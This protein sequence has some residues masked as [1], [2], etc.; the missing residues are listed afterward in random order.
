MSRD[1]TFRMRLPAEKLQRWREAAGADGRSLT[2]FVEAAV[3]E[4]IALA[5]VIRQNEERERLAAR[6][7]H[8][9]DPARARELDWGRRG[10]S[11]AAER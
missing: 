5:T 9:M 11:E 3:D 4:T 2:A 1:A 8:R 6:R 10:Q 7:F